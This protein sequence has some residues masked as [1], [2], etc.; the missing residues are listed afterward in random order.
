MDQ[1]KSGHGGRFSSRYNTD[2]LIYCEAV[3][4]FESAREREAQIKRWNRRMKIW[5]IELENPYWKDLSE[6]VEFGVAEPLVPA[7]GPSVGVGK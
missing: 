6:S 4:N 7:E 2:N 5:L 1:H 3:E